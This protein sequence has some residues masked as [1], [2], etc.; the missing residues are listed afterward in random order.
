MSL[1]I[2][3]PPG[4]SYCVVTLSCDVAGCGREDSA[5]SGWYPRD[6]TALGSRGWIERANGQ[7]DCGQHK[8]AA[9]KQMSLL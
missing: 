4:Y 1:L 3:K 7:F 6:R 5:S 8:P 2:W 9:S